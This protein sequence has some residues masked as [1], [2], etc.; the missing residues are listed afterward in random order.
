MV[1]ERSRNLVTERCQSKESSDHWLLSVAEARLLIAIEVRLLS[2]AEVK[3]G[4]VR[5]D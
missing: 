4:R 1:N 2:V 5:K 3:M